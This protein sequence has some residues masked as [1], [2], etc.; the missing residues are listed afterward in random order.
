MELDPPHKMGGLIRDT[1]PL[2]A[3]YQRPDDLAM[4]ETFEAVLERMLQFYTKFEVDA[5]C[6]SNIAGPCGRRSNGR[7]FE[8][9]VRA[10]SA[11]IG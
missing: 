1:S 7:K 5:A 2:G 8:G 11:V 9:V 6:G 3:A 4:S 10:E